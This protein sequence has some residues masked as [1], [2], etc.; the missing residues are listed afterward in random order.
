MN[1]FILNEDPKL[2][3]N[4]VI[5]MHSNKMIIESLQLLST[6]AILRGFSAPYKLTHKNHPARLWTG[7]SSANW[8]WLCI[9][10]LALCAE[11]TKRYKKIHKCQAMIEE[12]KNRTMEI[13]GDDLDYTLHTPFAQCMPEQYRQADAVQAYRNYYI[14]EKAKIAT[15]KFTSPPAWWPDQLSTK[16]SIVPLSI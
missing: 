8:N 10:G 4:D 11:Y 2:A 12:M 3:A 5:D 13:W 15:W 7:L 9:H 1:I 16:P 14:H 6:T